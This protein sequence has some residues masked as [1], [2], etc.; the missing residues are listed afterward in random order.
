FVAATA[1]LSDRVAAGE[2]G[3]IIGFADL[4]GDMTGAALVVA[5]GLALDTVGVATIAIGSAA[6]PT[7]AALSIL[8]AR[9]PAPE[10]V[11]P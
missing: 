4:L 7:L 11:V 2:R 10:P 9:R 3:T 8:L 1:E 5:G 6:L